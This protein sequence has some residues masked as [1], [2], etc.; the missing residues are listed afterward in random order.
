L[1][2]LAGAACAIAE[3]SD[4]LETLRLLANHRPD[5]VLID[6][7]MPGLNGL[8]TTAR[9]VREFPDLPV[10]A[11][12]MNSAEEFVL[13]SIRDRARGYLLKNVTP[14]ELVQALRAVL[15]GETYLTPSVSRHLIDDYRRLS[16]DLSGE[17]RLTSRQREVLQLVAEGHSTKAIAARLGSLPRPW[18][19]TGPRSWTHSTFTALPD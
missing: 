10:V 5:V 13:P 6:L 9:I 17:E 7:M 12:S 15:R 16:T 19:P 8:E 14:A 3:A 11:L 1:D 4:G 2:L 18:R